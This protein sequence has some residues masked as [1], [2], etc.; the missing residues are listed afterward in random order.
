MNSTNEV[1]HL[2]QEAS[3]KG[4]TVFLEEGKVK[5]KV[6]PDRQI[7]P[8]FLGQLKNHK[9]EIKVFLLEENK[10]RESINQVSDEIKAF[11]RTEMTK[12]PLS[13]AQERLWFIDQLEGSIHYHIPMLL[14]FKGN[15]DVDALE[16]AFGLIIQRHEVLRTVFKSDKGL[17][18]QEIIPAEDWQ[19]DFIRNIG[20]EQE[21]LDA[22]VRW[23]S[24]KMFDLSRD[25][26]FRATL[27]QTEKESFTLLMVVHHI[28]SD[29]W[30]EGIFTEELAECYLAIKENRSPHLPSLPIQYADYAV[31]QREFLQGERLEQKLSYWK[32][33]LDQLE[34]L[35]LPTDHPR[36]TT[37][38]TKG[39]SIHFKIDAYWYQKVQDLCQQ[40]Q[41]TPFMFLLAVFKVLLYRYSGQNDITVG[42]P[43]ANREQL[44]LDALIGFFVNT[45][46]LRSIIDGSSSFQDFLKEV[47]DMTLQA[48]ANQEVP[49]EKLV[50]QIVHDRELSRSP[51]FQVLFIFQNAPEAAGGELED[52][53][54]TEE[55]YEDQVAKFDQTWTVVEH[56]G[57]IAIDLN[58]CTAL[59]EEKSMQQMAKHFE[60]LIQAI[61][62]DP[63]GL[64][65]KLN[66][67]TSDEKEY[68]LAEMQS[69][70]N[71]DAASTETTLLELLR[72]QIQAHSDETAMIFKDEKL[73][74]RELDEL[75]NGLAMQLIERGADKEAIAICL[76]YSF[77][78]LIA[79]VGILK[80]GCAYVPIDPTYPSDRIDFILN[81]IQAKVLITTS[82]YQSFFTKQEQLST[83]L[84]DKEEVLHVSTPRNLP[85]VEP[86][87]LAY[88][89][90][91]SGSTGTPKGVMV[92]HNA[93]ANELVF[94]SQYFDFVEGDRQLLLANFVFDASVEQIFLPL[95]SGATL[96]MIT[97]AE[98]IEP[99]L[100]ERAI[101]EN[102]ITH[103]QATPSLIQ[104]ITPR[105]YT[106]LKRVCSG[107]EACPTSLAKA[108]SPF[109]DFYN[110]YG[111]TEAAVNV[112]F[113]PFQAERT[114]GETLPIGKPIDH[115]R[116]YVLD[117]NLRLIPRGLIGELYIGGVG[118]SKGYLNRPKLTQERFLESPFVEGER[119]YKTGDRVRM[120]ADGNLEFR[121][122]M[123]DQVKIR[124]YRIELGEIEAN[125]MSTAMLKACA[126]A[127]K[128]SSSG[129]LRLI[130]YVVP[131]DQFD[132]D[133][134]EDN[135]G[136]KL[137][138]Y[139]HPSLIIELDEIPLTT[140][141]KVNRK[142]LPQ[143]K[144]SDFQSED[145]M[146][147]RNDLEKNIAEV[148]KHFL[149]LKDVSVHA[150]FFRLGGHSLL[151][152]RVVSAIQIE[153]QLNISVGD[154]FRN[155]TIAGL[156]ALAEQ[157]PSAPLQSI[158]EQLNEKDLARVAIEDDF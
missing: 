20:I 44:E 23:E 88:I 144:D 128:P 3:G 48:Y 56:N 129:D 26:M 12:I 123:D 101:D 10:H 105:A 126:V 122:R 138:S 8:S 98:I 91:T 17:P 85:K 15:L 97:R 57:G 96:V 83:V 9:E 117:Q 139:M 39:N 153:S 94:Y 2:L 148:W 109:V 87:D 100:L 13:F 93:I 119:L 31:W 149:G 108:W 7:E 63:S 136:D 5:L 47:R 54:L 29:G 150:D 60:T 49:F 73:T 38:S 4:I 124:G 32:E 146:A 40:E 95:V 80:A 152:M 158:Q 62:S 102:G 110:K 79:M 99:Q 72:G 104:T 141:G 107:G 157:L 84:L 25:F 36:P 132:K 53:Q 28:A 6:A 89:I 41:V 68:L 61:V 55:T 81:D 155:P 112:S 133:L 116:L 130:A 111:P 22:L 147:P 137:P 35:E 37:Q 156:A 74:Y 67:I 70:G 92:P 121:G 64:I 142:L 34:P 151:A 59:F 78:M 154:L 71:T 50:E 115:A 58:F 114:Y 16:Q 82:A 140:S 1:L 143:P 145:F 76:D 42:T 18:F 125:M 33:Q 43:I 45:L 106:R 69:Q 77:E 127:A 65:D 118:V 11:D 103:F 90:Y 30:S 27:I 86:G 113:H 66:L 75:S 46:V 24:E 52:M 14:K 21:S 134:L 131:K 135:L 51:L 120:L 19:M